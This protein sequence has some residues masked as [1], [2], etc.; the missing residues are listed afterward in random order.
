MKKKQQTAQLLFHTHKLPAW[1]TRCVCDSS[2]GCAWKRTTKWSGNE[3]R[4]QNGKKKNEQWSTLH[5]SCISWMGMHCFVCAR[6]ACTQ[7]LN[8]LK[9]VFSFLGHVRIRSSIAVDLKI[10]SSFRVFSSDFKI[11]TR[12]HH[13]SIWNGFLSVAYYILT[14]QMS[15]NRLQDNILRFVCGIFVWNFNKN[16]IAFGSPVE[17]L[18]GAKR[19]VV[20]VSTCAPVQIHCVCVCVECKRAR[21]CACFDGTFVAN[22][23]EGNRFRLFRIDAS[24][25][26]RR[27]EF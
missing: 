8:H 10:D 2:S 6:N 22:D 21:S 5:F 26:F 4:A 24:T 15:S 20:K 25:E 3:W 19:S 27:D 9:A 17:I 23:H 16:V 7:S 12:P 11:S 14:K 18:F 13:N 1:K